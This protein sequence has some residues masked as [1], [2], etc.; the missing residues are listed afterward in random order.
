M[1]AH[2]QEAF[3]FSQDFISWSRKK[4]R[5]QMKK[6]IKNKNLGWDMADMRAQDS[7][8][9]KTH[10]THRERDKGKRSLI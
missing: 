5:E 10:H 8:R 6:K 4:I 3:Y 1:Y 7:I 9:V 2:G